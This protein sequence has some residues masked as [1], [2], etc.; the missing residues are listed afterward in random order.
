MIIRIWETGVVPARAAEYLAFAE[1]R[2]RAM[3]LE[4]P[5]CLGVL[6]LRAEGDRHAACTFWRDADAI[7]ALES[8][9]RYRA[10]VAALT[11][12]GVL[13]APQ[14]VRV[15]EVEGGVLDARVLRAIASPE[16]R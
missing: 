15:Y 4:Q 3:F 12:T 1:T 13:V 9:E 11:A 16:P 10:T 14:T 2:S 8:S 5:G 7:A 6:F